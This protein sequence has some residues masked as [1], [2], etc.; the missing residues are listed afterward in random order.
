MSIDL[1]FLFCF[2]CLVSLNFFFFL[3]SRNDGNF[4][5]DAFDSALVHSPADAEEAVLAPSGAPAVLDDPVILSGLII[6]AVADQQ[7]G[8]V[9]QLRPTIKQ[10]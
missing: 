4:D 3:N 10:K 7:N 1:F 2:V 9:G 5:G 8:V 6:R